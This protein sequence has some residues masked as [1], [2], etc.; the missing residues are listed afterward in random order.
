[1][2]KFASAV[3]IASPL[4][5]DVDEETL[6]HKVPFVVGVNV[7]DAA[8]PIGMASGY[9]PQVCCKDMRGAD[10]VTF[11]SVLRSGSA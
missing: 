10:G 5:D 3:R 2:D 6:V 8:H 7:F 11:P 4:T 1:M 9:E